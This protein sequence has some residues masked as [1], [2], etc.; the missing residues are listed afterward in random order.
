VIQRDIIIK[1]MV[2]RQEEIQILDKLLN[3]EKS[4]LL[5]VTGRRRVGKTYLIREY[6]KE[7]ICFEFIGTQ[8]AEPENQLQKYAVEI[9]KYFPEISK[10]ISY[11]NWSDA[12][13]HLGD[14][15]GSMRKSKKKKVVFI[16][17]FPWI[18][19]AKSNFLQEFDYWWNAWASKQNIVVVITGSAASWMI[20][21]VVNN[22]AGL[23]NRV[24]QRIHLQPFTLAETKLFFESKN[25]N[26]EQY[27]ILQ[28]YMVMGGIPHYLENVA[29]GES[30]IQ[31]INRICF[32]ANGLLRGEFNNL[33]AALFDHADNYVAV[34][35]ALAEKWKGLSRQEI[36]N[37]TKFTD[38]GGLSKILDGL[39]ACGFIL[40]TMPLGKK[41]KDALYRL[42]DEYS[43]FYLHFIEGSRASS[44]DVWL[45]K[46]AKP[47]FAIWQGYAFENV[48]MRHHD[49]IKAALGISGIYSEVSSYSFKGNTENAGFQIDMLLDRADNCM[50]I[51]EM[52]F[53][54]SEITVDKTMADTL[55]IRRA[56]FKETSKTKKHLFNTIITTYGINTN[57]YSLSQVDQV[58]TMDKLFVLGRF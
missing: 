54:N 13:K 42:I 40:K 27:Q 15:I 2:G 12:L 50:N 51:C 17:E 34:V 31:N 16:D 47:Q 25:I 56:R 36:I 30:A 43:L 41:S 38:G 49:A 37:A 11:K 48:C 21:K 28:L 14:C 5:I 57:E 3:S 32:Q 39:E 53:Y 55:R 6:F 26:L 19:Q 9:E 44:Q 33:Y 20:Q 46:S 52:K 4:E 45:Q 58:V 8:Y 10:N 29:K 35:R 24:T 7:N 1:N 18:A 23:H 22:K